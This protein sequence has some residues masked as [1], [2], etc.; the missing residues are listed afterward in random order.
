MKG[1]R[2]YVLMVALL[3]FT[4]LMGYLFGVSFA[5]KISFKTENAPWFVYHS[6]QKKRMLC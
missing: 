5:Y 2:F 3:L 1:I 4:G 6:L